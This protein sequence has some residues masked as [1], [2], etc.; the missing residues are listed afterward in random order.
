MIEALEVW[1]PVFD[2]RVEPLLK[3]QANWRGAA[4][5]SYE[6]AKDVIAFLLAKLDEVQS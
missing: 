1:T 2:D 4:Q 6:D 5:W 3:A